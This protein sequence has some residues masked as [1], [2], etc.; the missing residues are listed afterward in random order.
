MIVL[1]CVCTP[2]PGQ[3]KESQEAARQLMEASA[4]HRGLLG[5]FWNLDEATGNLVLVEVHENEA[6]VLNHMALADVSRL[7]AAG[8]LADIRLFGDPPSPTL[9][10]KL[11]G[12]GE[13]ALFP[14]L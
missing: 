1:T 9:L 4:D 3:E 6:S 5:Y 14:T 11:A 10:A 7:L 13:Y 2:H 8:T 12:F